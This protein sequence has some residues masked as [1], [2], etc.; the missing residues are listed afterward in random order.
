MSTP[1]PLVDPA[2][3]AA[4]AAAYGLPR[5]E[6]VRLHVSDAFFARWAQKGRTRR[7]EV[8]F[9]MPRPGGLLLHV[10]AD[11]PPE[12]WR[13]LTGGVENDEPVLAALHREPIEETGLA[14]TPERFLALLEYDFVSGVMGVPFVTYIFLMSPSDQP[15]APSVDGELAATS[16][17]PPTAL[18]AIADRLETL[19]GAYHGSWGRFRAVAHRLVAEMLSES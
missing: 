11:Y 15:L 1:P 4:L 7:G 3:V 10:K 17:A 8:M 14:V 9:L 13:L 6:R 12:C 16:V 2:E 19:D 5:H 18:P